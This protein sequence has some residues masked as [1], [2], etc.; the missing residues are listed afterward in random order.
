MLENN[1]KSIIFISELPE[2][3]K[4]LYNCKDQGGCTPLLRGIKK[5]D[6][7]IVKLL[8][9][10]DKVNP[11][12]RND[13]GRNIF[14]ISAMYNRYDI[15]KLVSETVL[16]QGNYKNEC[17]NRKEKFSPLHLAVKYKNLLCVQELIN[18]NVDLNIK[19]AFG[20]TAMH[21]AMDSKLFETV[22]LLY[23]AN[24]DFNIKN[25]QGHTVKHKCKKMPEFYKS[26]KK[27]KK[28][29]NN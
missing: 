25:N 8:L 7:E 22:K 14:H 9:S 27:L 28:M 12:S 1:I 2:Y 21:L 17:D 16:I 15:L 24:A 3:V 23:Q 5:S 29:I 19:D 4:V 11:F 18:I 10:I 26:L 6:M 20:N 13:D